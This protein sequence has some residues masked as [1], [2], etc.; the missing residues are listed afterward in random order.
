MFSVFLL[1]RRALGFAQSIA[2]LL[3]NDF[4][5]AG[6][7][8]IFGAK[9]EDV[10]NGKKPALGFVKIRATF[11]IEESG[12]PLPDV[13]IEFQKEADAETAPSDYSPIKLSIGAVINGKHP[14]GSRA[15][16]RIK[17][18]AATNAENVLVFSKEVVDI[19]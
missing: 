7:P 4:N 8:T 6:T 10:L 11:S 12:D 1:T 2:D 16:L 9:A 15:L 13:R 5:F 17:Q 19:K 3:A 18:K 14:D